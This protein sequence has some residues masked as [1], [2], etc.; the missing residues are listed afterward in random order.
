MTALARRP[1]PVAPDEIRER[2][3]EAVETLRRMRFPAG[4]VPAGYGSGWPEVIQDYW[5]VYAMHAPRLSRFAP[6]PTAIRRMDEAMRWF[7][8]V[9]N[10][11]HRKALLLRSI[12]LSAR[13]VGKILGVQ[14]D[15][16]IR[17][18]NQAVASIEARLNK[19]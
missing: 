14:K 6:G 15:T 13:R 5:E 19:M 9:E 16:A 3:R 17:W 10:A 4:A 18:E 7:Y 8:M 2:I 12:P 1:D 11:R